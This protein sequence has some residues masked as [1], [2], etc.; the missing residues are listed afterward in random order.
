MDVNKTVRSDLLTQQ[1]QGKA[2]QSR[3]KQVRALGQ[4]DGHKNPIRKR[5]RVECRVTIDASPPYHH[6]HA[7]S[8]GHQV[9]NRRGQ[10]S[11]FPHRSKEL[12]GSEIQ[13][14]QISRALRHAVN[15]FWLKKKAKEWLGVTYEHTS[16]FV[17]F[18]ICNSIYPPSFL[19]LT[20]EKVK[21]VTRY[22]CLVNV[23]V[24]IYC[25]WGI[26]SYLPSIHCSRGGLVSS[27][28][29]D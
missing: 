6:H 16:L 25:E 2:G 13:S 23:S 12:R 1:K 17:A 5:M 7:S 26:L 4:A 8:V 9:K 24:Y 10:L 27:A 11:L 29:Q 28:G 15:T 21:K 19:L 3:A 22:A 20:R 14:T 18:S